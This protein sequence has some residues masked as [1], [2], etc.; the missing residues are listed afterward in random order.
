[1]TLSL[2]FPFYSSDRK[3]YAGIPGVIATVAE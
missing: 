1:M 3:F 2:G